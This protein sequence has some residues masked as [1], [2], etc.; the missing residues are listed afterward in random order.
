[1]KKI[2]IILILCMPVCIFSQSSIGK[3]I[4]DNMQYD[5]A[6]TGEPFGLGFGIVHNISFRFFNS[7]KIE[8]LVGFVYHHHHTFR[9][10]IENNIS[11]LITT[12]DWSRY[13]SNEWKYY[14]MKKKRLFIGLGIFAGVTQSITKGA[15][16]I[17]ERNIY[18]DFEKHH[19]YFN[20]GCTQKIGYCFAEKIQIS[21]YSMISLNGLTNGR[22]RLS[23]TDSRF[24]VGINLGFK[25]NGALKTSPT[26]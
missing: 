2:L 3:F 17:P 12:N 26:N 6:I 15:L 14:P 24:L 22:F 5:I 7:A 1:M 16:K 21:L 9:S 8:G 25:I 19:T 10:A 23:E 11:P 18:V 4:N 20:Y 13:V